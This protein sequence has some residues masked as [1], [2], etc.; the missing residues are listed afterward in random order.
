MESTPA[1]RKL[2]CS[3]A[4]GTWHLATD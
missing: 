3:F 1:L 4:S 2:R